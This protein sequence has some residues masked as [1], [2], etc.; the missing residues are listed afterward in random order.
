[1]AGRGA[2]DS[3][4]P[5][6]EVA[7]LLGGETDLTTSAAIGLDGIDLDL[8]D[9]PRSAPAA[10][11]EP[12]TPAAVAEAV[13]EESGGRLREDAICGCDLA[14]AIFSVGLLRD[15]GMEPARESPE[16]LANLLL[17]GRPGNAEHFVVVVL[18][19]RHAHVPEG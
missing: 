10:R 17:A 13:V 11:P 7:L 18:R 6:T 1:V 3:A 16:S 12:F 19:S 9:D 15:V 5:A 8:R 4:V 14:K 2:G